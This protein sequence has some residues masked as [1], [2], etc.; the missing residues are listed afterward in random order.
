MAALPGA[1]LGCRDQPGS[2]TARSAPDP[3]WTLVGTIGDSTGSGLMLG[4]VTDVAAMDAG[5]VLVLDASQQTVWTVSATGPVGSLGR[6]GDGP[7]EFRRP[8]A[9]VAWGHDSVIVADLQHRALD[10]FRLTDT[11]AIFTHQVRLPFAPTDACRLDKTL[12]VL[13][14]LQDRAIHRVDPTN[15]VTVSFADRAAA[16]GSAPESPE[17]SLAW[18]ERTQGYLAC[19]PDRGALVQVT[20]RLGEISMHDTSGAVLWR[21]RLPGFAPPLRT[22]RGD[23]V[24]MDIDPEYGYADRVASVAWLGGNRLALTVT[25]SYARSSGTPQSDY[26][27]TVN[28][29]DGSAD[30]TGTWPLRAVLAMGDTVLTAVE[31]P[32]PHV[33]VW[34]RDTRTADPPRPLEPLK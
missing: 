11:A 31:M 18:H 2:S 3:D 5:P 15:G 10:F 6:E 34:R 12:Y 16:R 33:E 30:T 26:R 32:Y 27:L 28:L 23:H 4:Q 9:V 19:I 17:E 8:V 29:A 14:N 20:E 1:M 22:I 24:R 25:R 7:G 21:T 13:G